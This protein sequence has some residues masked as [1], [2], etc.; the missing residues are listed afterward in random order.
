MTD[1]PTARIIAGSDACGLERP[2][3]QTATGLPRFVSHGIP[4]NGS[5]RVAFCLGLA[6]LL[7]TASCRSIPSHSD[8]AARRRAVAEQARIT[9]AQIAEEN[10]RW[11]RSPGTDP[12]CTRVAARVRGLM[13]ER[14]LLLD[15]ILEQF[16]A[17]DTG[18]DELVALSC[19]L[20]CLFPE[21]Q[22]IRRALRLFDLPHGEA[23]FHAYEAVAMMLLENQ[24]RFAHTPARDAL[25]QEVLCILRQNAQAETDEN[26][27]LS[28][29]GCML[30]FQFD[31]SAEES[32]RPVSSARSTVSLFARASPGR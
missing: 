12:D 29:R 7:L 31:E 26:V 23:R 21:D 3:G 28:L 8:L 32:R 4:F 1:A 15:A 25:R 10:R 30:V 13:S 20:S 5:R 16:A 27:L 14:E 11:R 18:S 24:R 17:P 2:P 22:A 9:V 19:L 6:S